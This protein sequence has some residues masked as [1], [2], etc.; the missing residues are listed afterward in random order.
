MV[1]AARVRPLT[2]AQVEG[3]G[4]A[5]SPRFSVER[6][7]AS[8]RSIGWW[9]DVMHPYSM[10]TA[11]QRLPCLPRRPQEH[12]HLVVT[13][14]FNHA[15]VDLFLSIQGGRVLKVSGRVILKA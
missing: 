2:L 13:H 5:I 12:V 10:L 3:H 11:P 4:V 6:V 7:G 15:K 9:P 14:A 8:P 1:L